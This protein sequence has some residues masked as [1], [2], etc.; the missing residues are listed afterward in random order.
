[1]AFRIPALET[2][3]AKSYVGLALLCMTV[4]CQTA[5]RV[6]QVD[7]RSG[8]DAWLN[9]VVDHRSDAPTMDETLRRDMVR[10]V[11]YQEESDGDGVAAPESIAS[12]E[13]ATG[14]MSLAEAEEIALENSPVLSAAAARIDAAR[15]NWLQ[16]GLKPNPT[17]GYSGQ[18][19]GSGGEAEQ[20]GP[21]V[22]QQFITGGKLRLN[23]EVA[24]WEVQRLENEWESYR[25]RV[26][27]DV[28]IA[29]FEVLVAQRRRELTTEL[30]RISDEAVKAA[31]ALFQ[32]EEVSE[33]DPLR[34]RVEADTARILMQNAIN[35]HVAAWRRLAALSGMPE[36][37]LRR[38]DG[39]LN[40]DSMELTWEESLARLLDESPE[41]ASASAEV[42][43]ARWAVERAYAE[44]VP[45]IDVQA[46]VQDD[47]S[48]GSTN[49][50]LQIT[51]PLPIW[52][53]NQGGIQQ[54]FAQ[55]VAAELAVDRLRLDLQTRLAAAF[56]RYQ[57]AHNQVQAYSKEGGIIANSKRTLELIRSGYQAE[58][59]GI[60]DLLTAQRTFFQTNLAYLDSL[61]E[62]AAATME[63]RGLLLKESL[64]Q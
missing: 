50:N 6:S 26:L 29:F 10:Q 63:I 9:Q 21:F 43:A 7:S 25:L 47:R 24:A 18:Q 49:A 34:A 44:I 64:S 46:V 32:G 56:Q 54:A 58:E 59:F 48:T 23:R 41:I 17:I 22:G 60:L 51:L 5:D 45:D 14:V 53:R 31:Q 42:E 16:V 19:L 13:V 36:M 57:I 37:A 35:E 1:M 61:R 11:D 62:L 33:A 55:A 3:M 30:V 28:R 52:N 4:G 40:P 8:R 39:E 2:V 15:G 27:T 20:Q 38:V 12:P